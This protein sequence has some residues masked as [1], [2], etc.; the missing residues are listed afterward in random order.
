M[1]RAGAYAD[2]TLFDPLNVIDMASFDDP[3]QP[4]R[5]IH[6]VIVN[7][8]PVWSAGAATDARPGRVLKRA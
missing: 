4:A 2:L 6:T 8:V 7:G 3:T 1:L 5:G